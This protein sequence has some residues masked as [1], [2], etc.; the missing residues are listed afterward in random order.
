ML[1]AYSSA[2][3]NNG[4]AFGGI[5]VNPRWYNA[6]LGLTM[7]FGRFFMISAAG[8]RGEPRA[9]RKDS[10]VARHVPVTTPLFTALLVGV[11]VI[12]G[13]LTFVPALSGCSSPNRLERFMMNTGQVF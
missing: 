8:D 11:I 4:S 2:A 9:G 7:F 6:T 5:S 1:Y 10:G 12:V 3:A 13:A